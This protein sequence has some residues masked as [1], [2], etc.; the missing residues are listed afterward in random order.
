MQNIPVIPSGSQAFNPSLVAAVGHNRVSK[1]G[2]VFGDNLQSYV[3][4]PLAHWIAV[5]ATKYQTWEFLGNYTGRT[6][7]SCS[8]RLDYRLARHPL[9]TELH[10]GDINSEHIRIV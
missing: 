6:K 7:Q 8:D 9:Q 10:P 4:R 1:G 2:A 5:D 3:A